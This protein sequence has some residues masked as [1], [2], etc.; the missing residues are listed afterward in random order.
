MVKRLMTI[1]QELVYMYGELINEGKEKEAQNIYSAVMEITQA[2]S[3][4]N[5]K[6]E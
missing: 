3:R 5:I 6:G 4:L 1:K 2:I